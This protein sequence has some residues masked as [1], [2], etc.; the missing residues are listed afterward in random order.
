MDNGEEVVFDIVQGKK[1][2]EA[3]NVTGP[4]G[5]DV[6]GS[7]YYRVLLNKYR[8]AFRRPRFD[9][10]KSRVVEF[11]RVA[12]EGDRKSSKKD[13]NE[14]DEGDKDQENDPD[15][16]VKDGKKPN[17]PYRRRRF[18]R[19]STNADVCLFLLLVY[20]IFSLLRLVKNKRLVVN[21]VG[22][23]AAQMLTS[24]PRTLPMSALMKPSLQE[25]LEMLLLLQHHSPLKLW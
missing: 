9:G 2:L 1:G 13:S 19:K 23:M 11:C 12:L 21:V 10:N 15:A 6:K 4:D 5:A 7:K 16:E 20:S 3:S 22:V 25:M 18:Q 8:R 17:R 14:K 24:R